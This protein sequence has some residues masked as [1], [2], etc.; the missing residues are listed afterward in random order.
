M[1]SMNS[2]LKLSAEWR[3]RSA[4]HIFCVR[5]TSSRGR[6]RGRLRGEG[7][8]REREGGGE[9]EGEGRGRGGK[10]EGEEVGVI[11]SS[12]RANHIV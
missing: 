2:N 10:G 8:G 4:S 9:G 12:A 11:G 6:G 7:E 3:Q 1:N 5:M